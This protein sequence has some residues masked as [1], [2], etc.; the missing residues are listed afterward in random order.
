MLENRKHPRYRTLARVHI[1]GILEGDSLLKDLSV[2]GCRV[3]CT[4]FTDIMPNTQYQLEIEP[5][6]ASNVDNFVLAV[7]TKWIRTGDYSGEVGFS[8]VASPK[9]KLFQRYVDY[10]SYRSSVS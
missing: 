7:E 3:E 4:A 1:P 5:E 6:S 10:L 9:G 8:I 2:T